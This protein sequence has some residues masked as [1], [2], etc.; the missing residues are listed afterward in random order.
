MGLDGYQKCLHTCALDKSSQS[1]GRVNP[2]M[3][4]R[5]PTGY[6]PIRPVFAQGRMYL[7]PFM[8]NRE[9]TGQNIS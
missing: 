6:P 5:E 1:I 8:P 9:T 7:H 4:N 3:P 2:I